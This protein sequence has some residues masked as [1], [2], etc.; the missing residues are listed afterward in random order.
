M[1]RRDGGGPGAR[2]VASAAVFGAVLT[3]R[4]QKVWRWAQKSPA[5]CGRNIAR[6]VVLGDL[7]PPMPASAGEEY[8]D[9]PVRAAGWGF[10]PNSVRALVALRRSSVAV[11]ACHPWSL[12]GGSMRDAVV[13]RTTQLFG[14]AGV[15]TAR[16]DFRSGLGRGWHSVDDVNSVARYLLTE[17]GMSRRSGTTR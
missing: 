3:C 4:D 15:T 7:D 8:V 1:E 13:S 2:V 12:L 16:F 10:R 6:S 11:I 9:I 14:G 5:A 17:V